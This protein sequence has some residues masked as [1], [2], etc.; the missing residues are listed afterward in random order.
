MADV[1]RTFTDPRRLVP[2]HLSDQNNAWA[3]SRSVEP[4]LRHLRP[5]SARA[6]PGPE[7]QTG[8]DAQCRV[9]KIANPMAPEA[10]VDQAPTPPGVAILWVA[11]ANP[12]GS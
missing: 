4:A 3:S 8:H 9:P 10:A 6:E 1:G 12:E 11:P 7:P 5:M 2:R